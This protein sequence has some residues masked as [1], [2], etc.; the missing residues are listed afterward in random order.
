VRSRLLERSG[1]S[2]REGEGKAP[3]NYY[4]VL[5]IQSGN[6]HAKVNEMNLRNLN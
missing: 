4:M 5:E 1:D 6:E 2:T 3:T